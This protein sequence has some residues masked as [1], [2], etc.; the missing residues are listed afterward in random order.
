ML[1]TSKLIFKDQPAFSLVERAVVALF[2]C[3]V[4]VLI[5]FALRAPEERWPRGGFMGTVADRQ[6]IVLIYGEFEGEGRYHFNEGTSLKSALE[7][8]FLIN[9]VD[10]RGLDLGRPLKTGQRIKIKK[11]HKSLVSK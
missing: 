9:E 7:V 5:K 10:V 2:V 6:V 8:V 3:F 1:M 4:V 11:L